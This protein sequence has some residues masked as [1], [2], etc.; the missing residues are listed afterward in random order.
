MQ[1]A[2]LVVVVVGALLT[3]VSS[4]ILAE[5]APTV[6]GTYRCQGIDGTGKP[7]SGTVVIGK[8]GD[9]YYVQWKVR[10]RTV[11]I[12]VGLLTGNSLAVSYYGNATGV[13]LYTI[14]DQRLIGH[15]TQP[16][17]HGAVFTETLT[18]IPHDEL[19]NPPKPSTD[20][21]E[22]SGRPA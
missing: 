2:V 16:A 10:N 1:H 22:F 12:G 3:Q 5:E 14:D 20:P 9:A 8:W 13:A 7:Y 4:V 18:R 6:T 21:A 17:A 11:A 19:H 15:W